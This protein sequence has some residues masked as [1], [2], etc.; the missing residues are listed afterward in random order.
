MRA[1]AAATVEADGTGGSRLTILRSAAPL[2]LRPTAG[3]LYLV[4]GAGGPLG[5]D[6]VELDIT[7]GAG[8]SLV[9]RSAAASVT[10]PDGKGRPSRLTV[11][12][13]VAAG[14][15]LAWFPEPSVVASG[16]HQVLR[17][18]LELE[19]GCR[20]VWREEVILGR[21][22]EA[23]GDWDSHMTADLAGRPFVRHGLRLGPGV[24]GWDGPAV[25][26]PAK[27]LGSVLVVGPGRPSEPRVEDG[28]AILPLSRAGTMITAVAADALELRRRLDRAL[29][30]VTACQEAVSRRG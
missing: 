28:H 30:A 10:Q 8:A 9:V 23:A 4:G 2:L 15:S 1:R 25:A 17:T 12:A 22:A 14:G 19:E 29:S 3:A 24:R 7:V 6:D 5:G 26:G 13:R 27:A 16:C 18:D 21:H 11:R 20:L